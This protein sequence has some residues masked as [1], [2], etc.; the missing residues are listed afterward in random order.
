LRGTDVDPALVSL[1]I[2]EF[3]VLFVAAAAA[4]GSSRFSG[5][6]ELRVKESDRIAAMADGLRELGIRVD[7]S[8]DGAVVHGGRLRG[9]TVDSCADHRIAMAFAIA[10]TI[11]ASAVRV[12]HTD[13]VNTSFPGFADCLRFL[14]GTIEPVGPAPA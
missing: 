10:G 9:G 4:G 13:T 12:R 8:R 7:E 2:D 3:P 6:G 1:A 14:G 5:I 11:A